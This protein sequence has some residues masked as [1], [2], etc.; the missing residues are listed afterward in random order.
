MRE[1]KGAPAAEMAAKS[2]MP[3]ASAFDD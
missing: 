1:N 3:A 2:L